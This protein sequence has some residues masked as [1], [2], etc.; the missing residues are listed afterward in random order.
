MQTNKSIWDTHSLA[1][2]D[3][4]VIVVVVIVIVIDVV[5]MIVIDVVVV[6]VVVIVVVADSMRFSVC[7]TI[8][9]YCR[10]P[11]TEEHSIEM[12]SSLLHCVS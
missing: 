8:A 1:V 3:G 2:G 6:I 7:N 10:A 4:V 5:V 11:Q 12:V 9:V